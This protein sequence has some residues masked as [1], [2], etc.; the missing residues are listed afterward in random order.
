MTHPFQRL[1]SVV[2]AATVLSGLC[3]ATTLAQST[4]CG[5]ASAAVVG[6][7]PFATAAGTGNQIVTTNAA[8]TTTTT[9]NHARWFTFTPPTTGNYEFSACGSAGDTKLALGTV[10]PTGNFISIAY[11][12]DSCPC[13]SGC[14]TAG[15]LAYSSRLNASNTG[16][17]LTQQLQAGVTY[18]IVIGGWGSADVPSGN[19][20]IS[21]SAPPPPPSDPCENVQVATIGLNNLPG[22]ASNPNL[23]VSCGTFGAVAAAKASYLKFTAPSSATYTVDTCAATTDTIL[24]VLTTCGDSATEI[25]CNDDTCGLASQVS[26]DAVAGQ[27]YYIAVGL[28]STTAAPP[29]NYLV[30]VAEAAPP[31][32]PCE[33]V[34][35]PTSSASGGQV[36]STSASASSVAAASAPISDEPGS[37]GI[38]RKDNTAFSRS[39]HSCGSGIAASGSSFSS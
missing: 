16:L 36:S 27:E 18:R 3:S 38:L 10:C 26:F 13:T 24:A 31:S 7:N 35:P 1:G 23:P 6:S 11:N 28:W 15:N 20:V 9:I 19:L 8:G 33:S 22:N 25:A 17:P 30:T 39:T 14:G 37:K 21:A 12:D 5:G 29:A 2:A 32:D 4:T 34:W